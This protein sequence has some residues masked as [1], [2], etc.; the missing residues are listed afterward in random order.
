MSED[1]E[2]TIFDAVRDQS[3]DPVEPVRL[4]SEDGFCFNCHKGVSCWNA[5]CTGADITLTPNDMLRLSAHLGLRPKKFLAQYTVPAIWD[6]A[7]LPVAKLKMTED[8][9][10]P[11]PF[12]ADEGC[13]VYT[14]RPATCRYYPLGFGTF[15]TKDADDITDFHF[16][17]KEPHCQGHQEAK[18]QTVAEFR[19]EQEVEPYDRVNRAWMDIIMKLASWKTIGGPRGEDVAPQTKQM[20]YLVSTD[21][22]TF[23]RFV[24]ESKFLE[25]YEID[26]EA[27]EWVKNDDIALMQLGFD[28]LRNV[29]FNEPTIA[30]KETVLQQ[31]IAKTR[32]DM[33]AT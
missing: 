24:L 21:P 27:V 2:V 29:I 18:S 15:K 28:W 32:E 22:D 13:T 12:V 4:K 20:F 14:D 26:P 7:G 9:T 33:G 30:M 17:V 5:C 8:G 16:L 19:H 25:T 23:R 10:G 6:A 31:A 11:C 3:H 1:G